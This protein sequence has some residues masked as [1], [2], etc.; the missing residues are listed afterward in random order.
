[1]FRED[2]FRY[3]DDPQAKNGRYFADASEL[4]RHLGSNARIFGACDPAM[5]GR[6]QRGDYS[7]IITLILDS[8][9]KEMYVIGADIARRT[10][11]ELIETIVRLAQVY[12]FRKFAVES[13]QFQEVIAAL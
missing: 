1:M 6:A 12:R 13:N 8:E 4:L 7:A 10:P 9:T 5:G 3:W 2:S 11:D